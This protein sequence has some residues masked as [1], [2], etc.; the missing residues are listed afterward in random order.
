M[1]EVDDPR[2]GVRDKADI[3]NPA[4]SP[5]VRDMSV[6]RRLADGSILRIYRSILSSPYTVQLVRNPGVLDRRL[7]EESRESREKLLETMDRAVAVEFFN[8]Y[9]V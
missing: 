6:Q 1:L 2:L 4:F 3:E 5:L 9:G 7:R 8:S